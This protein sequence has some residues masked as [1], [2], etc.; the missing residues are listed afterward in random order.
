[1]NGGAAVVLDDD[2]ADAVMPEQQCGGH[3]DK[4]APDD[5]N[6]GFARGH[7]RTRGERARSIEVYSAIVKA[8]SAG[9][10]ANAIIQWARVAVVVLLCLPTLHGQ[11]RPQPDQRV[12]AAV[13]QQ[14]DSYLD[15][16]RQL[17]SIE[18]GSRDIEGL[19]RIS[20]LIAA[21]LRALGGD[22]EMVTPGTDAARFEDTP[23]Q[24]GRIVVA[25]FRGT[26]T[27][28]IL[29]LAHMDTVYAKGMGAQQPFRIDGD[30]AYGLGIADDKHGVALVL[31]TLAALQML[32]SHDYGL[33]TVS[34]NGDEEI[35]APGARRLIERLG[36]EHDVVLSCEG[37]GREDSIR[38]ATSGNGTVRMRV[39]GRASH[40]GS[41]P[42][43]GRN[44]LYELAHQILQTRDLSQ[45]AVGLKMN[46]TLASAGSVRNAIPAS[47]EATAD[48]RVVRS[49]DW[50]VLERRV[51]ERVANKLIPDTQVDVRVERRRP[52]L[53]PTTGS[54]SLGERAKQIYGEIGRSLAVL[55]DPNGG[56]TDAAIAALSTQAAVIEGFGLIG[57]GAHSNDAESI[58]VR[59]IEPRLYLL[60]RVVMDA[61]AAA[62]TK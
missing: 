23:Q 21:R 31:H 38:L 14:R 45:P 17:V 27:K 49:S 36:S 50:D 5:E 61:A 8:K 37:S 1:M 58:D 56:A 35:S 7:Q 51:R 25:R 44:A 34:I 2:C 62:G 22:V 26:G 39:T 32:N 52:A 15:T 6:G 28:K 16:L 46:W 33:L 29:L 59:S 9:R 30:R 43:Q 19:N 10:P 24:I 11:P 60:T 3:P 47:A 13:R 53:Q 4:A 12:L 20:D 40:A 48:V 42:E 54:R 57:A 41:A 55:D 18:S